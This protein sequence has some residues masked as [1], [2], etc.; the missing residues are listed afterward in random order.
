LA[1]GEARAVIAT[2]ESQLVA[3]QRYGERYEPYAEEHGPPAPSAFDDGGHVLFMAV[4]HN[5]FEPLVLSSVHLCDCPK[6]TKR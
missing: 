4:D 2:E 3:T 1:V 5:D 6:C